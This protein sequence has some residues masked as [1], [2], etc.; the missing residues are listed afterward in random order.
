MAVAGV[1]K[2]VL[3]CPPAIEFASQEGKALFAEALGDGTA[4]GF[5]RLIGTFQ[6][7]AE[8][9]YCGLTTL[10]VVLN[11]LSIDPGRKWKGPWR[12]FDESMLDCCEP[13]EKVKREGITFAKL[14]CLAQCAGASVQAFRANQSSLTSFRAL[15][16]ACVSSDDRHLIISYD[17]RSFQQT[18]TGHFSP[19]GGYHRQKD[20][21]LILD[22]ARFKYP[23]H[24]VPLPLLWE[25]INTIDESTGKLRGFM[26]IYKRENPPS[27]LFTLSCKD[28]HWRAMSKHLLEVVPQLLKTTELTNM[29]QVIHTVFGSLPAGVASFVKWIVEV[30]FADD[31]VVRSIDREE[32][33]RL[34][35]KSKVLQQLRG[36]NAFTLVTKWMESMSTKCLDSSANESLQNMVVQA[37]CQGAAAFMGEKCLSNVTCIKHNVATYVGSGDKGQVA[38]LSSKLL[39]NGCEQVINALVPTTSAADTVGGPCKCSFEEACLHPMTGDLF[40]ILLLALP[41]SIWGEITDPKLRSEMSHIVSRAELPLDLH[42]EVA[43]LSEQ[44]VLVS[45]SCSESEEL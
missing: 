30:T 37:C 2:R 45:K 23:P 8:P 35:H 40:S 19:L 12:W 32:T 25:A 41:M 34:Q 6:T 15:V 27:F 44:A 13:L 18:G 29:E 5:F 21:A 14:T 16:E 36:T 42:K 31:G 28:E 4:N 11:A 26:M 3:P 9:A 17:R 7:Q 20:M 38:V 1:Y 22:V 39:V 24:W 33:E 10:S 43:H